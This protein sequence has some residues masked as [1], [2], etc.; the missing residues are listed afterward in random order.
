VVKKW[1]KHISLLRPGKSLR[2]GERFHYNVK[3][4]TALLGYRPRNLEWFDRALT[5][6]YENKRD[7]NGNEY[8]YD[9]LEFLGDAV[10]SLVVSEYLFKN[11]PGQ[12][13]GKLSDIRAQ[14]VSRKNLNRIGRELQLKKFFSGS[15]QQLGE[16]LEGNVLEA[17]TGA[18]YMDKGF[19]AAKKFVHQRII[20]PHVNLDR[21]K[22]RVASHKNALIK[23]GQKHKKKLH[24]DIHKEITP[25]G[26]KIY[27]AEVFIDGK[28]YGYGKSRSKK[29]AEEIAAKYAYGKLMRRSRVPKH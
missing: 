15:R 24:F 21:L 18:I 9:R 8:N 20:E 2:K 5:H 25:D 27:L 4:L 7:R 12:T 3:D 23:W 14:I 11:L 28:F 17:L 19:E 1:L 26:R 29:K 16:N 10:I 22:N 6:P 13:E